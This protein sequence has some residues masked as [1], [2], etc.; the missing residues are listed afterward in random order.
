MVHLMGNVVEGLRPCLLVSM[1]PE[2]SGPFLVHDRLLM[3]RDQR[4]T[5]AAETKKLATLRLNVLPK[6]MRNQEIQEYGPQTNGSVGLG[7]NHRSA[8]VAAL[9]ATAAVGPGGDVLRE[10]E[11]EAINQGVEGI[12]VRIWQSS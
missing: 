9:R 12:E 3:S 4:A 11:T 1:I 5:L 8:L 6:G 10:A 2:P 7:T